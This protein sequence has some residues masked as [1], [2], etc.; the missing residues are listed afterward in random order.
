V[1]STSWCGQRQIRDRGLR[2]P[3]AAAIRVVDEGETNVPASAAIP[4]E[5]DGADGHE[6]R[7]EPADHDVEDEVFAGVDER[8]THEQRIEH[9]H[10]SPR[11]PHATPHEDRNQHRRAGMQRWDGGDQI[12]RPGAFL[13]EALRDP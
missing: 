13:D 6:N 1:C 9:Q 4:L 8:Q 3:V 5:Q 12:R 2:H 10:Q 11:C 7:E